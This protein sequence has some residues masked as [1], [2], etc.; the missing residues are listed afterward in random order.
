MRGSPRNQARLRHT[1]GE[2]RR[3]A[4]RLGM[5]NPNRRGQASTHLTNKLPAQ[6]EG[7]QSC[8]MFSVIYSSVLPSMFRGQDAGV[9]RAVRPRSGPLIGFRVGATRHTSVQAYR[10]Y[11]FARVAQLSGAFNTLNGSNLSTS[12]I[13]GQCINLPVPAM[14]L[15]LALSCGAA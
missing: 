12:N 14:E 11:P 4:R 8:P 9:L 3:R 10:L 7:R 2:L 13:R 6:Y 5:Q 1:Q 15:D